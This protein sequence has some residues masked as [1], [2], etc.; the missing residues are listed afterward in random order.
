MNHESNLLR[1]YFRPWSGIGIWQPPPCTG[2]YMSN[3]HGHD[4]NCRR[5]GH[6]R[7]A[8]TELLRQDGREIVTAGDGQQALE[9]LAKNLHPRLIVLDLMMRGMDGREFL[10]RQSADPPL[11]TF[12]RSFCPAR[13]YQQ[14]HNTRLAQPV[15]VQ[16]LVA[17]VDEY[18]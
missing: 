11:L 5:G 9:H 13:V 15:D 12:L 14:E 17:L 10:R 18:C 7:D 6:D 8:L 3:S 1:K 2:F 4:S 16:R